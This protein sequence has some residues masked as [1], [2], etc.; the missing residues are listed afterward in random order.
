MRRRRKQ[1]GF[2]SLENRWAMTVAEASEFVVMDF[3]DTVLRDDDWLRTQ[4]SGTE[5]TY[6]VPKGDS[7]VDQLSLAPG[8]G[9]N[10]ST[11]L[12]VESPNTAAGLP[13]FF[14]V[15]NRASSGMIENIDTEAGYILP[16][17]VQANR[18]EFWVRFED[19][20]RAVSSTTAD[21]N[22]HVG[23]YHYD[24][25]KIVPDVKV[26]ESD[27]WH[28][29]HELVLRHDRARDGWMHVVVN[30]IPQHQRGMNLVRQV[31]NPTASAG[32]YYELLTRFYV[33]MDPYFSSPETGH[34]VKMWVDDIKL[35]YVPEPTNIQVNINGAELSPEVSVMKGSTLELPVTITNSGATEVTGTVVHRSTYS[36]SPRLLDPV[37]G[38]NLHGQNI[39]V[40]PGETRDLI[41]QLS[42]DTGMPTDL[43]RAHGVLF[44]PLEE[45]RPGNHS[46]AD[47]NVELSPS[48]GY[49]GPADAAVPGASVDVRLLMN[50]A[51]L[52][53]PTVS[54]A[55]GYVTYTENGAAVLI[56]GSAGV[57]DPEPVPSLNGAILT[58]SITVNRDSSRDRLLI[59]PI[60]TGAGQVSTRSE[61]DTTYVT[62]GGVDVATLTGGSGTS[63]LVIQFTS[64]QATETVVRAVARTIGFLTT[65]DYPSTADR[66]VRFHLVRNAT[67]STYR[68]D[69]RVVKVAAVADMPVVTTTSGVT[70]FIEDGGAVVVDAG[71]QVSD[72]D[73]PANFNGGA[74]YAKIA[75]NGS[76]TD[77]LAIRHTGTGA[78]QIGIATINGVN[79]VTY[80]GAVIGTYTGGG[81]TT[82]LVVTFNSQGTATPAAVQA[83]ARS[84]TFNNTSHAPTTGQRAIQFSL[85]DGPSG[86][87]SA[88]ATK[89]VS[90]T[91]MPDA[92]VLSVG[93]ASVAYTENATLLVAGAG[94]VTDGDMPASFN[95]GRLTAQFTANGLEEDLLGIKNIGNAAGQIGVAG[96]QVRYGGVLIGTFSGGNA[97]EPLV[98]ALNAN[99]SLA[100]TKALLR[101]VTYVNLSDDPSTLIRTIRFTLTDGPE[102]TG[103]ASAPVSR[104]VTIARVNDMPTISG[105]P[106]TNSVTIGDI[107]VA[108]AN[109]DA[110]VAD[111]DSPNFSG[112]SLVVKSLNPTAYDQFS[113]EAGG[114]ITTSGANVYYN[115]V[116]F[117]TRTGGTGTMPLTLAFAK[118]TNSTIDA[119]TALLRQIRFSVLAGDVPGTR[120]LHV[121]LNDGD[122]GTPRTYSSVWQVI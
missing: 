26:V 45:Q 102:P 116:F 53:P 80:G 2:E 121:L 83:L 61:N 38:L 86:L 23:T 90:V 74:F 76:S 16:R 96:D 57:S 31:K 6:V 120:T 18:L 93:S 12:L 60:G 59:K 52:A 65:T 17:G 9:R 64:D 36:F 77:R 69:T 39:T 19:G 50:P 66:T 22:M 28:Y 94:T 75:V 32:D 109:P 68:Q 91:A 54:L 58:A 78:G 108:V 55:T 92:P 97:T 13:G 81:G 62:Y 49:S 41:L 105:I 100:A 15:R 118:T 115:G 10:G 117:A 40:A 5:A 71:A 111:P 88:V 63:D 99:A 21:R 112:G 73:N 34:P 87:T 47:P 119:A 70:A 4:P 51:V 72:P 114:G 101:A 104:N 8:A 7:G 113:I 79:S 11:A 25:A 42:T 44:V 95:G 24:P 103:L 35:S 43:V 98:V 84:I 20:F 82:R 1:M 107:A 89:Q 14:V 46:Q 3:E 29:Y 122:G 67:A 30:E 37:S 56:D 106:A 33:D 27:N 85:K 48:N 110:V